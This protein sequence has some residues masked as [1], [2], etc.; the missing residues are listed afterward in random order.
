[1]QM[2]SLSQPEETPM[3]EDAIRVKTQSGEA[4]IDIAEIVAVVKCNGHFLRDD[5]D[6][7]VFENGHHVIVYD[8]DVHTRSGTIFTIKDKDD[9]FYHEVREFMCPESNTYLLE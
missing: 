3:S 7:P 5:S 8:I 4:T 1:M 6:K 9:M 2:A